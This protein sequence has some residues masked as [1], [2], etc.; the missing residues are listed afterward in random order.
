M[1][2]G[3]RVHAWIQV[4]RW[5]TVAAS[6]GMVCA[7]YSQGFKIWRRRSVEDIHFAIAI[8][9]LLSE[10]A[11]INYGLAIREWPILLICG[12]NLG[13]CIMIT[14]GYIKFRKPNGKN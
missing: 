13:A 12:V 4:S 14:S 6:V 8:V 10:L 7:L 5:L 1:K 2:R 3:A 9:P 11:W